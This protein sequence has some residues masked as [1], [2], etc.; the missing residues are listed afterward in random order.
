[1]AQDCKCPAHP[2]SPRTVNCPTQ[3]PLYTSKKHQ[4]ESSRLRIRV[5]G[6]FRATNYMTLSEVLYLTFL[7][8]HF[9]NWRGCLPFYYLTILLRK[10]KQVPVPFVN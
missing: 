3:V 2:D 4:Q 7:F 6:K 10:E 1:M 5:L 9:L 8:L